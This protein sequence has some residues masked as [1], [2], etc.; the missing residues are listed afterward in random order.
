MTN[1]ALGP[2]LGFQNRIAIKGLQIGPVQLHIGHEYMEQKDTLRMSHMVGVGE[3][4]FQ[5]T[6]WSLVH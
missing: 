1:W 6:T 5:H 4:P 2:G 3:N